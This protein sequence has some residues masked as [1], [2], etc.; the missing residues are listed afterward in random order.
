LA[1]RSFA[2]EAGY[3]LS[4]HLPA[5]SD[6]GEPSADAAFASEHVGRQVLRFATPRLNQ[7]PSSTAADAALRDLFCVLHVPA[8]VELLRHLAQ[9][10][11]TILHVQKRHVGVL[12]DLLAAACSLL[13]PLRW[14]MGFVPALPEGFDLESALGSPLPMLLG[15]ASEAVADVPPA[16]LQDVF[17]LD[18]NTG[19][20]TMGGRVVV[21]PPPPPPLSGGAS[22]VGPS[23]GSAM[24]TGGV[25]GAGSTPGGSGAGAQP[26]PLSPPPSRSLFS[27]GRKPKTPAGNGLAS[28]RPG[29]K[30]ATAAADAAAAAAL[31]SN[32]APWPADVHRKLTLSLAQ[33]ARGCHNPSA[34]WRDHG[35]AI[36][37]AELACS[38]LA[39]LSAAG[40]SFSGPGPA[41]AN[42]PQPSPAPCT[43]DAA[44]LLVPHY[45]IAPLDD[46]GVSHPFINAGAGA[47]GGAS[48]LAALGSSIRRCASPYVA[49]RSAPGGVPPGS[50]SRPAAAAESVS[51]RSAPVH[52]TAATGHLSSNGSSSSGGNSGGGGS[53]CGAS[54]CGAGVNVEGVR[55]ACLD[56][57]VTL[58]LDY[59]DDVWWRDAPAAAAASPPSAAATAADGSVG[60]SGGDT[61]AALVAARRYLGLDFDFEGFAASKPQLNVSTTLS[62]AAQRRGMPPVRFRPSAH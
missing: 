19:V 34:V 10:R 43:E 39:S 48:Q 38:G 44:L 23:G 20:A 4:I 36:A 12:P 16:A 2:P 27:F 35:A 15:C 40:L 6:V 53:S 61:A 62:T 51:A 41:Q 21:S 54:G 31:A 56:A 50:A 30:A 58:L 18:L 28:P 14:C 47:G 8:V 59:D 25:G 1:E 46:S 17:V 45:T 52:V 7:V 60:A 11:T 24:S 42:A 13:F 29:S 22:G 37:A 32:A 33:F 57:F 5:L 49:S 55:S 3:G 9:E 26:T